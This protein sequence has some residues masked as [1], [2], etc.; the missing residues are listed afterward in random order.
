ML[1]HFLREIV[2]ALFNYMLLRRGRETRTAR[3]VF[4]KRDPPTKTSNGIISQLNLTKERR[5]TRCIT[6]EQ[7]DTSEE[8]I[9]CVWLATAES[10]NLQC[11]SECMRKMRINSWR[12]KFSAF[13]F[14]APFNECARFCVKFPAKRRH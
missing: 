13:I 5:I 2:G 1:V 6:D 3:R 10:H 12:E 9:V 4:L 14:F 8:V 7:L 11:A